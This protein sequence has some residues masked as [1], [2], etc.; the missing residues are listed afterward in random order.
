MECITCKL[1]CS[2]EMCV[3][4]TMT[5]APILCPLCR[6]DYTLALDTFKQI[7]HRLNT[8][9]DGSSILYTQTEF[10]SLPSSPR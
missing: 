10:P 6:R 2:H 5:V 1:P 9:K 4:C 8:A 3:S 7:V